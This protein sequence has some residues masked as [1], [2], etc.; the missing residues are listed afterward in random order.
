MKP[1]LNVKNLEMF[2]Y[3]MILK[4]IVFILFPKF[5]TLSLGENLIFEKKLE[6]SKSVPRFFLLNA[7]Q[8]DHYG[9]HC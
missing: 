4:G 6:G 8:T 7:Y 5:F 1:K 3:N 9:K 2:F